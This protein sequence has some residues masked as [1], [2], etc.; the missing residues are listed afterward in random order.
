MA[1]NYLLE[2]LAR[3]EAMLDVNMHWIKKNPGQH[4]KPL[5]LL[6]SPSIQHDPDESRQGYI[7]YNSMSDDTRPQSI[8]ALLPPSIPP[9]T[10]IL[11]QSNEKY[12]VKSRK[13]EVNVLCRVFLGKIGLNLYTLFICLYI[14]CTLWAY[15]SVF[16]SALARTVPAFQD[17]YTNYTAY[18][19]LFAAIVV[20]LSCLELDEQ[21]TVQVTLTLCRFLMLATM[22]LTAETCAKQASSKN[23]KEN[24]LLFR[25]EGIHKMLPIIVF[26]HIYHHSIPGL[27]H[28]VKDKRKLKQIFQATCFFTTIA[29]TAVGLVLGS[30]FGLE[31]IEQSSNLNWQN[32]Q[33]GT[34]AYDENGLPVHGISSWWFKVI[35]YYVVLFPAADVVSAFPLNAI[36]LGNNLMG[37][38]FGRRLLEFESY[39]TRIQFRLL[40][41]CLPILLGLLIRELGKITDDTVTTGFI[42]ALTK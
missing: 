35:S 10:N 7:N 38:F 8:P 29:Y 33:G 40:A 34:T 12:C 13:F 32:Y 5:P 9:S 3:A 37:S 30:A 16:S 27:S 31:G 41:A 26:A 22:L 36:T 25:P 23:A 20:P 6:Y 28:P 4:K 42:V 2:S 19:I 11:Q 17:E 1:K 21:V 39:R 14:Y 18:A 15:T 24:V